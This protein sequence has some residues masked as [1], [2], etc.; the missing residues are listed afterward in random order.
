MVI[1]LIGTVVS[2]SKYSLWVIARVFD[3]EAGLP[4]VRRF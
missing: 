3:P 2:T 1:S 4:L